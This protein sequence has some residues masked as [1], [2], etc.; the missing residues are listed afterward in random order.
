MKKPSPILILIFII[1]GIVIL[2]FAYTVFRDRY[3]DEK[4]DNLSSNKNENQSILEGLSDYLSGKD[5]NANQNENEN[6]SNSNG[7]DNQANSNENESLELTKPLNITSEDCDK[8]CGNYSAA[9]EVEYC[10]QVCGLAEATSAP[11]NANDNS[12]GCNSLS[13]I[14]KDYCLKDFAVSKKS[15]SICNQI[16]DANIKKTCK[17]RVTEEIIQ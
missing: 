16:Q 7:N 10:R 8:E 4:E 12:G 13:G 11:E 2:G 3:A 17:N 15:L 6:V 5:E 1:A 9:A 14:K